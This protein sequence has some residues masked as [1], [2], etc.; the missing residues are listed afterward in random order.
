[1]SRGYFV[2]TLVQLLDNIPAAGWAPAIPAVFFPLNG[3]GVEGGF[4]GQ[5]LSNSRGAK[6]HGMP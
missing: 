1:M 3:V 6:L 4:S 2:A 5:L